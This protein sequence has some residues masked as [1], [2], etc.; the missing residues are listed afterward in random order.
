M[1]SYVRAAQGPTRR[2]RLE[3]SLDFSA[4]YHLAGYLAILHL[5]LLFCKPEGGYL[6]LWEVVR[7][8]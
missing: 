6:S 5:C 2:V 4:I 3:V 1:P 7:I 8:K